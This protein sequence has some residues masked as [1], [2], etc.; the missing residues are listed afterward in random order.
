MTS[1]EAVDVRQLI[2]QSALSRWQKRLIALCFIVVALD[3][4]D[5]ALMGFIAPTLKV[6]WGVT[7]HQLGMVISAALI[8]LALG[9][10]VAGPLADRYGRRVMILLSVGFF[11]LWTLATA[12][13]QNVE[14]MMLFRFLTGLGLGRRCRMSGR[15]WRNTHPS[16]AALSLLPWC[17]VAL[18]LVPPPVDLPHPGCCLAM[19]GIR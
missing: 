5:I 16:A 2:N 13:A 12:M 7:N 14:Q 11:G 9:A 8:G 4:M 19:T 3:G 6:S 18:P 1:V 15:W 10:M 17:F